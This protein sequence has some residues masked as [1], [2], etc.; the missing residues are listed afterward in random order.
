MIKP[1]AICLYN[2]DPDPDRAEALV[3]MLCNF[4]EGGGVGVRVGVGV[5]VDGAFVGVEVGV[6]VGVLVG[7][8]VGVGVGVLIQS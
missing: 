7:V 6:L 4:E 2:S 8:R 5:F 1:P 3:D